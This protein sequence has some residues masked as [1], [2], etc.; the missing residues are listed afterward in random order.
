M[1]SIFY[2]YAPEPMLNLFTKNNM[3]NRFYEFRNIPDFNVPFARIEIVSRMPSYS[4]PALWNRS[5]VVTYHSN[6]TTFMYALKEEIFSNITD[7]N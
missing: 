5:G 2:G 6:R 7:D 3:E 4:L 1:H